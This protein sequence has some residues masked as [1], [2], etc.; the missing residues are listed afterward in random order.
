MS[1]WDRVNVATL[2]P[3]CVGTV[4]QRPGFG[5]DGDTGKC[6]GCDKQL[7]VRKGIWTGGGNDE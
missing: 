1:K 3:C 6:G 4:Q 2:N 5:R 7:T